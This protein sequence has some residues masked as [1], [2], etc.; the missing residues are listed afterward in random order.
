M[1]LPQYSVGA[2]NLNF[3]YVLIGPELAVIDH[4][5]NIRFLVNIS[6]KMLNLCVAAMKIAKGLKINTAKMLLYT[7]L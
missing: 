1:L 4:K 7:L 3:T 5:G 6:M 2:N